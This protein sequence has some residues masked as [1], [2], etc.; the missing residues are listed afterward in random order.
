M[1]LSS[2]PSFVIHRTVA[3]PVGADVADPALTN[4]A[5]LEALDFEQVAIHWTAVGG[6]DVDTMT[7]RVL[8]LDERSA[9]LIPAAP[10]WLRSQPYVR[11]F[12]ERLIL[13]VIGQRIF[14]RIDAFSNAALNLQIHAAGVKRLSRVA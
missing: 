2:A 13:P 11:H 14:V 8:F 3:A 10:I 4:T 6:A 9:A 12:Q 5:I 1:Q 7:F